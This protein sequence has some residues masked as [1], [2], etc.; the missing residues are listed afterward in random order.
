M[1]S[2][3]VV[4]RTVRSSTKRI[5]APRRK[6]PSPAPRRM[7][8]ATPPLRSMT[9]SLQALSGAAPGNF[10]PR[11]TP[12]RR[13]YMGCAG[14]SGFSDFTGQGWLQLGELT[15]AF[16]VCSRRRGRV[17]SPEE[18][19]SLNL[20]ARRG[21]R[22]PDHRDLLAHQRVIA[23]ALAELAM[24]GAESLDAPQQTLVGRPC[25]KALKAH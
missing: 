7:P 6:T 14:M 20:Y 3:K 2:A 10:G 1:T 9:V 24:R 18:R 22:R 11:K 16:A 15:L 17:D 5:A 25:C 21:L 8:P 12:Y 4:T 13:R 23:E 19:R